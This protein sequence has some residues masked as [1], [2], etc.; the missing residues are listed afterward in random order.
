MVG[1]LPDDPS[2]HQLRREARGLQ[3]AVVA[4]D[5]AAIDVVRRHHPTSAAAL[6]DRFALHDAELT[7][8]RRHGFR[9]WPALVGYLDVVA[10]LGADPGR[11]D[12]EALDPADRFCALASLRYDAEDAPPRWRAAEELAAADPTVVRR[13]V[14]AA[15]TAADPEALGVH[16]RGDRTAATAAGGPFGWQP[17][18]YL[19]YSRVRLQ[20][21]GADVLAAARLLLEAGA[22]PNS[23]YLWRGMAPPFTVLTGVFGEGEQGPGRQPRHPY[24]QDLATVLLQ[25]GAHPVDHQSLYNRMFRA[26]DTHLELLFA[27]GLA[28]AGPSPWE[29]R[30]GDAMETRAQMW[31]RQIDWAAAHGFATRLS[32]LR[33]HGIDVGDAV[34]VEVTVPEDPNARDADGATALHHAAFDGDLER[35]RALLAAGADPALTDA[36]HGT[37]ARGWAEYAYQHGAAELLRDAESGPAT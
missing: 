4:G 37:T 1:S 26:D 12:E 2:I 33:R 8:A 10:A 31:R 14:W 28:T 3:R 30:L 24:A 32:L 36:R 27:F 13:H 25:Y 16:L 5:V 21:S 23:G 9:D 18:A 29:R 22:D 17:L 6:G 7:V 20:R 19:A 34:A 11:V 15:A 35:I